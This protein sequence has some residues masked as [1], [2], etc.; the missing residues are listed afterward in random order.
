MNIKKIHK[1]VSYPF[2][3][4]YN[5][6]NLICFY[7]YRNYDDG[8]QNTDEVHAE[9]GNSIS[10]DEGNAFVIFHKDQKY[11]ISRNK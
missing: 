5:S 3:I 1:S 2:K 8:E 6:V 7:D 9:I 4:S 11:K 10:V